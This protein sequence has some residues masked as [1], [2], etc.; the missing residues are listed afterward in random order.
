MW[1]YFSDDPILVIS[2]VPGKPAFGFLG[3]DSG[4][5]RDSSRPRW[6]LIYALSLA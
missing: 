6:L 1:P 5:H 3:W 2:E 4:D